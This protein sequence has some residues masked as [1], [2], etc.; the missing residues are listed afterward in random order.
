MDVYTNWIRN[1]GHFE[2]Y[3]GLKSVKFIIWMTERHENANLAWSLYGN[4]MQQQND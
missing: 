3:E 4:I 2:D 1:I